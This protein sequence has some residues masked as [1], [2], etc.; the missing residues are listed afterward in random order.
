MRLGDRLRAALA[1]L[2]VRLIGSASLLLAMMLVVGLIGYGVVLWITDGG[3]RE[4]K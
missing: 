4:P 2:R 1:P 3:I